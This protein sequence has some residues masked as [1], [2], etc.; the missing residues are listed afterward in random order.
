[1]EFFSVFDFPNRNPRLLADPDSAVTSAYCRL[2][3][4][5]EVFGLYNV[6][7]PPGESILAIKHGEGELLTYVSESEI[8]HYYRDS[9]FGED[10][11][12]ATI[13]AGEAY[14]RL[15][16]DNHAYFLVNPSPST[17]A[18]ARVVEFAPMTGTELRHRIERED[19]KSV[20]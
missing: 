14:S 3:R 12:F 19:R 16:P 8:D 13:R 18:R 7:L 1:M 5:H 2:S 15:H 9:I 10:R 17:P 11:R 6:L 4:A 20:V